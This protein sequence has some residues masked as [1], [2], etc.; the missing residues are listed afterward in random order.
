[1]LFSLAETG[2][3]E[4]T[5]DLGRALGVMVYVYN[6]SNPVDHQSIGNI[7]KRLSPRDAWRCFDE[8]NRISVEILSVSLKILLHKFVCKISQ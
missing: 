1:M 2:K 5:K 7:S 3:I 8:F 4:T 6:C